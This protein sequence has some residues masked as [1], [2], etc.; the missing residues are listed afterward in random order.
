MYSKRRYNICTCSVI[1]GELFEITR[2]SVLFS[3]KFQMQFNESENFSDSSLQHIFESKYFRFPF[4]R[5]KYPN[6]QWA[7][8]CEKIKL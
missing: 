7:M 5:E 6:L 2:A 3:R 8:K 4:L 1:L